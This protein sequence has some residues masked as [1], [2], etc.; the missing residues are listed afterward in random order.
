MDIEEARKVLWLKSNPRPLGEL[1]DKGYLTKERLAWA[2]EWAYNPR[3]KQAAKAILESTNQALTANV[4]EKTSAPGHRAKDAG[5]EIEIPLDKARSTLWPFA[6]YKGQAMGGLADSQQLSLKDLGYAIET[7]WDEKVKQAAIA[8]SLVRLKQAVKE[9]VPSAGF[10]HVVSGGRSYAERRETI[11]TLLQGAIFGWILVAILYVLSKS[12]IK[13]GQPNPDA[14]SIGEIASAPG[15]ILALVLV[16]GSIIFMVWFVNFG[17]DRITN[18]IDKEIEQYRLGQEGEDKAVQQIIQAL[19]GNWHLFRNISLPGQNKAD[20]DL[21]LVGPPGVWAL[22]VKNF[23]GEY[24]NIGENWEIRCGNKWKAAFKS[25]ST[26]AFNNAVRLGNFL[27]ADHAKAFVNPVV[28]WANE[29]SPLF[30]ENPSVAVWLYNRLLDELGNI[31]QG[32][33][34]SKAELDKIVGKLTKLCEAQKKRL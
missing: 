20:L 33:R 30:V 29:E 17:I 10:V 25:P 15:G 16:F 31:W 23:H 24:R 26:Q 34:L 21:V 32:E 5:V 11:L 27:K 2:A 19:D 14:K 8:L 7:A 6:P 28:V 13:S 12:I 9:P 1:L 3:L 4:E 18:K 22:E